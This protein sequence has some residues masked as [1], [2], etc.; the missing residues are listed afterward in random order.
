M[1]LLNFLLNQQHVLAKY[2]PQVRLIG[3]P[4]GDLEEN[5]DSVSLQCVADA[6]P[7]A[8]I[9]WRKAGRTEIHS[10]Q[11]L[12]EFRPLVRRHAGSYSCEA[13]NHLGSSQPITVEIDVK[14]ETYFSLPV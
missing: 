10:F 7:P 3:S 2:A 6:N 1:K 4:Q 12:I 8:T 5:R 9:V 14:C 13:K 11:E